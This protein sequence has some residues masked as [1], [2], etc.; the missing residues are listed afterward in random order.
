MRQRQREL[1]AFRRGDLAA[2]LIL[3]RAAMMMTTPER[4]VA[5]RDAAWEELEAALRRAGDRPERLGRRRRAAAR[6]ALP[7]DGRR[8]RVRAPA[9]S[10]RSA[11]RAARGAGAARRAPRSTRARAGARRCGRSSRAA[12]GVRLAERPA[13]LLAAW[14]LL[15]VPARGWAR[16][17]ALVDAPAAAGLIPARVPVGRRPARRGPRLRRRGGVR[18]LRSRSCSTTSR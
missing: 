3:H 15:L 8:P 16:S 7:R 6:R 4:F 1:H 5:E 12:T 10:R 2:V 9:L 14:L 18:V 11:G 13:L 17:G